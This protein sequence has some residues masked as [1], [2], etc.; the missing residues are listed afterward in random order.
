MSIVRYVFDVDGTICFNGITIEPV[1]LVALNKLTQE[2]RELIFASAR[3]IRDLM[4]VVSNF[5]QNHLIGG[6]GSIIS[7]NGKIQVTKPLSKTSFHNILQLIQE[8]QLEYIVDDDWNYSA[9]VA[10]TNPIFRQLD[11][12]KLAENIL[13]QEIKY[14]IKIIL[15]NVDCYEEVFS[16]LQGVEGITVIAHRDEKNIDIT[17]KN[18]NKFTTLQ[19]WFGVTEYVAFGNDWNDIELLNH[20]SESYFIGQKIEWEQLPIQQTQ[21]V[22]KDVRKVA[23]LLESF[24][25]IE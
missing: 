20:A 24:T 11:P 9:N 1:I 13:L 18:I 16:T 23:A 17:A 22:D 6:N 12:D 4:P 5:K 19:E 7:K 21:L 25:Q 3:P 8:Y 2:G 14:P 15:L 10:Q